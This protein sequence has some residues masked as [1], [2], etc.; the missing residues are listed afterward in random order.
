[1]NRFRLDAEALRD[2]MIFAAGRLK[3]SA[4]GPA[5]PLEFPENVGGLDPKDVNPPSFRLSKWR[6]DQD[7]ERTI[8]LPVVRYAAQP[9]PAEL[10]NVFDF[11]QPSQFTGKRAVTAVPTQAL[12]LMNSPV[13]KS[14]PRRSRRG[15]SRKATSRNGWRSSG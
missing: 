4:G 12:F 11:A 13:V 5:L 15:W 7:F 14:M 1:M 9:G 3:P 6:P 8:Y 10:R 2:A